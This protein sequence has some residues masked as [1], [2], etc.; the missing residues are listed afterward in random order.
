MTEIIKSHKDKIIDLCSDKHINKLWVFG[1]ANTDNFSPESDID[2]LVS[3]QDID[4]IQ[5]TDEYFDLCDGLEQIFN[6]KIDP[7]H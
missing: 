4:E 5:Y 3:F 1:S 6:R 2:F 7:Y